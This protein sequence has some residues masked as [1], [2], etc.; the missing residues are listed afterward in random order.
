MSTYRSGYVL[1]QKILY[2]TRLG[3]NRLKVVAM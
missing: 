1:K 3:P 2:P